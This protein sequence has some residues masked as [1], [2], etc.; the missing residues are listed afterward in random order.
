MS[1]TVERGSFTKATSTGN[2]TVTLANSG[3]TCKFIFFYGEG[4]ATADG[5]NND[6]Y[7][8]FWGWTSS[9]ESLALA[10]SVQSN[11][12]N[13]QA[14]MSN[15][16]LLILL[17]N[18]TVEAK[19]TISSMATAGQ[20]TINWGTNAN[21][22]A[23]RIHYVAI[24]GDDLTDIKIGT[25]AL[26]TSTGNQT[27]SS[28]TSFTPK[29]GFFGAVGN[30][31]SLTDSNGNVGL[32]LGCAIS[33]S[34]R[35]YAA[36]GGKGDKD[37]SILQNDHMMGYPTTSDTLI[38]MTADFVSFATDGFTINIDDAPTSADLLGYVLLGG[39]NLNVDAGVLS[40]PT[41]TGTSAVTT[42]HQPDL[43]GLMTAMNLSSQNYGDLAATQ[44][45][46]GMGVSSTSRSNITHTNPDNKLP[47]SASD[48]A[49]VIQGYLAA[50]TLTASTEDADID[51]FNSTDFTLDWTKVDASNA[52]Y[53]GWF[54]IGGGAAGYSLDIA[55]GS[56]A[57]SGQAVSTLKASRIGADSGSV[58]VSGAAAALEAGR[59]VVAGAGSYADSGEDVSLL[60]DFGFDVEAGSYSQ[61][62]QNV[63]VLR[64]FEIVADAGGYT[65]TGDDVTLS[66]LAGYTLTVEA[67]VYVSSGA[68]VSVLV[69][70]TATA[71]AGSYAASGQAVGLAHD[72]DM[73]AAAGSYVQSGQDVSVL[74]GLSVEATAG[75]YA[76]TGQAVSLVK[77]Y[78]FDAAAG[79]Y[80]QS[81]QDVTL[82]YVAGY[83]LN[84]EAGAYVS[85]GQ[86]I[87]V[88]ADRMAAADA[89]I[90][91]T[92]GQPAA[93]VRGFNMPAV[94][95]SYLQNGEDANLLRGLGVQAL[96]GQYIHTG[97]IVGLVK[98][99]ALGIDAGTYL[100]SGQDVTL[101][102]LSGIL[103]DVDAG[104]YGISGADVSLVHYVPV[105]GWGA[106]AGIGGAGAD[107]YRRIGGNA[108]ADVYVRIGNSNARVT[109][110][111]I[112][113]DN[114]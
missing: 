85:T 70:R 103:L 75:S 90:Y 114:A 63:S 88:T 96:A 104:N 89:G 73:A 8:P 81:G 64:G 49:Y 48:D 67:G 4:N 91:A 98:D 105:Y 50:A 28:I 31:T 83:G 20:F 76:Q 22:I 23:C 62:G 112:G 113:S 59:V 6:V 7:A 65:Q 12:K 2:Q 53:Y 102:Y 3:L 30:M 66:Y 56:Y 107:R 26:N 21:N 61:S 95:G 100:E 36:L 97:Q 18:S 33:S 79:S 54:T 77:D 34:K 41:S 47:E 46:Y 108:A 44:V 57:A 37:R 55:S 40:S 72:Y 51:S 13:G 11:N 38:D 111:G 99:Y 15:G 87:S 86:T 43:V 17:E 109:A 52:Y 42:T 45:S 24:G 60:A 94:E 101:S 74:R 110:D 58:S 92:T 35:W 69:D 32:G 5:I 80:A 93:L 106:R 9:S 68:A 27:F 84:V 19:A 82:S 16:C 71:D 78:T 1:I 14:G 25:A 39:T 29:I 10:K